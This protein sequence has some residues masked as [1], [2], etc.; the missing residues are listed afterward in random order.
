[1]ECPAGSTHTLG[2]EVGTIADCN[3]VLWDNTSARPGPR[4]TPMISWMSGR[5]AIG[6]DQ[7]RR[8]VAGFGHIRRQLG[9]HA[10]F[11]FPADR[12]RHG[13]QMKI[14]RVIT[15]DQ[16]R[17]QCEMLSSKVERCRSNRA[18]ARRPGINDL[19]G[20]AVISPMTGS[21]DSSRNWSTVATRRTAHFPE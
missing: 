16:A 5:C 6:I 7:Q 13:N 19:V 12:A 10:R 8:L 2:N 4:A 17:A 15:E 21:R 11:A 9:S 3:A 18:S 20:R 14:G 1:M